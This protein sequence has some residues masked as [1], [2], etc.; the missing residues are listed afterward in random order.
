MLKYLKFFLFV[1]V[2]FVIVYPVG[3]YILPA[4][5]NNDSFLTDSKKTE[6]VKCYIINLDR[7]KDRYKNIEPLIKKLQL[8]YQRFEAVD[9]SQLTKEYLDTIVD[10][11]AYQKYMGHMPRNGTIGCSLSHI[12]LW[13]EFLKTDYEYA[14]IFED[15]VCFNPE[16]LKCVME[17]VIK[18]HQLWDICSFELL[19]KG[20]PVSIKSLVTGYRLSTYL[21][22]ITHTG[23]YII[24][25][26]AA[27]QLLERALPIQIP[28][29]HYFTRG[30]ELG[31]R[32]TGVEPRLVQQNEHDSVIESSHRINME[33]VLKQPFV[34]VLY[35]T[36]TA[37]IYF[38][39]NLKEYVK[40]KFTSVE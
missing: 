16:Q 3:Y 18:H 1:V 37:I 11:K 38:I 30:W 6:G 39:H 4:P 9:G 34:K 29:D 40:I 20:L 10:F 36:Q 2:F 33:D 14:F 23:C 19:H 13:E 32:F 31:L 21:V 24:S 28:I 27:R 25:R 17:D 26:K 5:K 22:E 12:R 15:D 7:S 8:P 35:K